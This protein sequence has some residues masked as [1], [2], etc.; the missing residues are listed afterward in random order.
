MENIISK[1]AKL[2]TCKFCGN[3]FYSSKETKNRKPVFCSRACA[4]YKKGHITWNAGKKKQF[5]RCE[6]CGKEK[7][8]KRERDFS[9]CHTCKNKLRAKK[10]VYYECP[11][12]GR[13]KNGRGR[14]DR[15]LCNSCASLDRW[16]VFHKLFGVNCENK[17]YY[18]FTESLKRYVRKRQDNKCAFCGQESKRNRLDVH[19]IDYDKTNSHVRNLIALCR[20]C[21]TKTNFNREYWKDKC[22]RY[23]GCP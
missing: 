15:K 8:T 2:Y 19:H 23:L 9:R 1:R 6:V 12:C 4:G 10:T 7:T 21:H 16:K 20:S 3:E 18:G 13:P 5:E 11:R 17:E 14:S 22:L